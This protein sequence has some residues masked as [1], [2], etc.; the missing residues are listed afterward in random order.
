MK[1]LRQKYRTEKDK[2]K[3]SG[4]GRGRKWQYFEKMDRFLA[5]RHNVERIALVDTMQVQINSLGGLG[6]CLG[7]GPLNVTLSF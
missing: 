2:A 4:N 7:G 1:K 5:T 6:L 3:K